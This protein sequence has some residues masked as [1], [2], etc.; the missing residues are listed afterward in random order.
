M[1]LKTVVLIA[2]ALAAGG[3]VTGIIARAK[4]NNFFKWWI[5][6]TFL[7]PVA[8]LHALGVKLSM[9]MGT[10]TCGYCRSRVSVNAQTCPKCGYEFIDLN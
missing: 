1:E 7:F 8:I 10:K 6:G 2:A 4:G 3:L 5:Y 9:P